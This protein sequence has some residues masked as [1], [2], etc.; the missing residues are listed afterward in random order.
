MAVPQLP[1]IAELSAQITG[2]TSRLGELSSSVATWQVS[3]EDRHLSL[4]QQVVATTSDLA[5][6]R[7]E[8]ANLQGPLSLLEAYVGRVAGDGSAAAQTLASRVNSLEQLVQS[9]G[10]QMPSAPSANV[11]PG[12]E[13]RVLALE[14]NAVP[15]STTDPLAERVSALEGAIETILS[16]VLELK[17]SGKGHS[18]TEKSILDSK[19]F[20]ALTTFS[21]SEKDN[22][23][24]WSSQFEDVA[25]RVFGPRAKM[26]LSEAAKLENP[27]RSLGQMDVEELVFAS[28]VWCT[29]GFRLDGV[30]WSFRLT[31]EASNG[32]QLW[33]AL[34]KEYDSMRDKGSSVIIKTQL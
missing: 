33:R 5:T 21:H 7:S 31:V 20:A 14:Q 24:R 28:D 23:K 6:L 4:E 16:H 9:A 19:A 17:A 29:L 1:T 13:Q 30:P 18:G 27:V 22:F 34:C 3:H 10:A 12:L 15:K 32:L 25:E 2:L 26:W 8:C 11:S